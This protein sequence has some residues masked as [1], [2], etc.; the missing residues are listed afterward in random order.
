MAITLAGADSGPSGRRSAAVAWGVERYSRGPGGRATRGR[1]SDRGGVEGDGRSPGRAAIGGEGPGADTATVGAGPK[2][3]TGVLLN[4]VGA[5]NG[6]QEQYLYGL[7][8]LRS[9]NG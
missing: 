2:R 5:T 8:D 1:G 6:W 3:W 9:N 7:M 4:S